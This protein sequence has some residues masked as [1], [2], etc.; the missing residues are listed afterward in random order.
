MSACMYMCTPGPMSQHQC[1]REQA[2][3]THDATSSLSREG[4]RTSSLQLRFAKEAMPPNQ[5]NVTELI[6]R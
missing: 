2:S 1:T 5:D 4:I 6:P 3:D